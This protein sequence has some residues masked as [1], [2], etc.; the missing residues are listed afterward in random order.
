MEVIQSADKIPAHL[1]RG[2]FPTIKLFFKT[3]TFYMS[4]FDLI[5][6][7]GTSQTMNRALSALG[8]KTVYKLGKGGIDPTKP[9]TSQCDCSG[10]IAW[11][12]GIPRELPPGSNK[13]LSTD[14]YWAEGRPVMTGMFSQIHFAEV[15]V[16]DL[17]VYPD[18]GGEQ[19]HIALIIRVNPLQ[20]IHCSNG[21]FKHFGDAICTG[22]PTVFLSGNHHTKA[23]RIN[24]EALRKMVQRL[25]G[26]QTPHTP[27]TAPAN[28][29]AVKKA[30]AP[31]RGR[32]PGQVVRT[33]ATEH[34][35]VNVKKANYN[36][37]KNRGDSR[38]SR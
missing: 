15:R 33:G 3:K 7:C 26:Q 32:P 5:K 8:R 10:F 1:C 21:N 20:I 37:K 18:E 4:W 36:Q 27:A 9:L 6:T 17:L 11:A 16:G 35:S 34:K 22:N 13:W 24:Y 23:M 38:K 25:R 12:M 19:G 31:K 30:S 28:T 29:T 14:E 2:F